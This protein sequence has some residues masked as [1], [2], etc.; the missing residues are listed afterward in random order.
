MTRCRSLIGP[1]T[2]RSLFVSLG[3][4]KNALASSRGNRFCCIR[5]AFSL[6]NPGKK[7]QLRANKFPHERIF[8][9]DNETGKNSVL[10]RNRCFRPTQNISGN[11]ICAHSK[12]RFGGEKKVGNYFLFPAMTWYILCEWIV[13]S[14]FSDIPPLHFRISPS[15]PH[16]IPA[17]GSRYLQHIQTRM[18]EEAKKGEGPWGRNREG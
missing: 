1:E 5:E 10:P 13:V 7:G 9:A 8:K 6:T 14:V 2:E 15:P 11:L 4:R 3:A 12:E 16:G 18:A 17:N